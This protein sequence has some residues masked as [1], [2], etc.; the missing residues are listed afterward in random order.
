MAE[1]DKLTNNSLDVFACKELLAAALPVRVSRQAPRFLTVLLAA[2]DETDTSQNIT[3]VFLTTRIHLQCW[4]ARSQ[5]T[6]SPRCWEGQ[7]PSETTKT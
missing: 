3:G 7:R 1:N 2:L 5:A 4:D 6:P